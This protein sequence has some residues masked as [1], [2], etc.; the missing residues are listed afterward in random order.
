[1]WVV[2]DIGREGNY[3]WYFSS[4]QHIK[5]NPYILH[6]SCDITSGR[7]CLRVV[8]KIYVFVAPLLQILLFIL[9][10]VKLG[11]KQHSCS[12]GRH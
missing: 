4:K 2:G 9:L 5:Y 3:L 10:C 11:Q 7:A 6:I 12:P 1:M 8:L